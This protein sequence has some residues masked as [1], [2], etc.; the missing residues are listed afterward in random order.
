MTSVVVVVVRF[1]IRERPSESK[2]LM[3]RSA[4]GPPLP[5]TLGQLPWPVVGK[6]HQHHFRAQ[7]RRCHLFVI[8]VVP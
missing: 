8:K 6:G 5:S 4:F 3:L 2:L 7:R 1:R